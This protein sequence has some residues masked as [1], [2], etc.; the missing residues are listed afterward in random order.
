MRSVLGVFFCFE[1]AYY[2]VDF[3]SSVACVV[4]VYSVQCFY[5]VVQIYVIAGECFLV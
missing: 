1:V 5:C 3:V 4:S 2:V